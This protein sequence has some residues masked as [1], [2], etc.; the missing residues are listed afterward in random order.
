MMKFLVRIELIDYY[1]CQRIV[2]IKRFEPLGLCRCQKYN[3]F[4]LKREKNTFINYLR[5]KMT[6]NHINMDIDGFSG[7]QKHKKK[8]TSCD[9]VKIQKFKIAAAAILKNGL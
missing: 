1:Y 7:P 5:V 9:L 4:S 2:I 8:Y 6:S 3:I